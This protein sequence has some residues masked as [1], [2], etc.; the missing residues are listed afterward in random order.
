MFKIYIEMMQLVA[1][2]LYNFRAGKS[3]KNHFLSFIPLDML[4][5]GDIINYDLKELYNR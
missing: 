3:L 4:N 1:F 2:H 5:T